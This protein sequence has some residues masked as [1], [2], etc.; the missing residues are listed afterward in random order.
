MAKM[1]AIRAMRTRGHHLIAR[2][3]EKVP[4]NTYTRC[5]TTVLRVLHVSHA[6]MGAWMGPEKNGQR[7]ET[8]FGLRDGAHGV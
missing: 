5:T 8:R 4:E 7:K 2:N 3:F 6:R 1:A